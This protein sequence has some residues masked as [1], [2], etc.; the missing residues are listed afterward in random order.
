[1]QG[2]REGLWREVVVESERRKAKKR[3]GVT[4]AKAREE[5]VNRQAGLG[6]VGRAVS[7]LVSVGLA[8]DTDKVQQALKAKFP[9][10]VF[11]VSSGGRA[12][13]QA[14]GT[15]VEYFIKQLDSFKAGAGAGP[16]GLRPQF[17]K[18]LVG[19]SG[20]DPCVDA[21]HQVAVLFAEARVPRYLRRWY[22]G[23]T[24]IGIGKDGKP[25]D[26]D[27]RPIVIGEFW[28]RIAGKLTLIKDTESLGG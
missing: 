15:E 3:K 20:D 2:E 19:V 21:M 11:P 4:N 24:L 17:I 26:E 5:A 1:M 18:E 28:R 23:G 8:A 13:P 25:L 10:R 16:T 27:A 14:S 7:A 22:G 6:R 9:E 12:L